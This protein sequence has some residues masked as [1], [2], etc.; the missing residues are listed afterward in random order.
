MRSDFGSLLAVVLL[1]ILRANGENQVEQSPRS[2][3]LQEE[4]A[5]FMSCTYSV[6]GFNNLQWYRQ[7][8]G[9]GPQHLFSMYS[10]GDGK[11]K[12]RVRATLQK[13]GSSLHITALQLEDSATYFCAVAPQCSQAPG[14]WT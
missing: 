1:L 13:N 4:G 12:G 9:K 6:S 7:D 14:T 2:L 8:S 10:P 3:E 11:S 5:S